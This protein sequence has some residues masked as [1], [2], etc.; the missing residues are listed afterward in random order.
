MKLQWYTL[1]AVL[2]F[3]YLSLST[4]RDLTQWVKKESDNNSDQ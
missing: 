3:N 4:E 2:C 1:I